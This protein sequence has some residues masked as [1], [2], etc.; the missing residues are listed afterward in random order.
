M[1]R[2][3]KSSAK[4]SRGVAPKVLMLTGIGEHLNEMTSPLFAAD[5]WVDKPF[6]LEALRNKIADL[7]AQSLAEGVEGPSIRKAR[8]SS[9]ALPPPV[10]A[11]STEAGSPDLGD[12]AAEA[13]AEAP[14]ATVETVAT[15]ELDTVASGAKRSAPDEDAPAVATKKAAKKKATKKK[16]AKKKAAKKK[17]TKRKPAKLSLIHI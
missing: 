10:A 9:E 16:A 3:I 8:P 7:G 14:P 4:T 13:D 6:D 17:A 1:C 2:R 12:A 11:G 5:D 15:V